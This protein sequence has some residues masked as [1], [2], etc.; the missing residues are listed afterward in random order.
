MNVTVEPTV[1]VG[2]I[3]GLIFTLFH[4]RLIGSSMYSVGRCFMGGWTL[5]PWSY[6]G[7]C[8]SRCDNWMDFLPWNLK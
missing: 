5:S 1:M 4:F 7:C 3:A 6:V 8:S 2:C